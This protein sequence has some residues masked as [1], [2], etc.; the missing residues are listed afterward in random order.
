MKKT[1]LTIKQ[2]VNRTAKS[3]YPHEFIHNNET[4]TAPHEIANKFNSY[5][6]SIGNRLSNDVPNRGSFK[7]Y[8]SSP[9][10]V[11]FRFE[12][13]SENTVLLIIKQ[14]KYSSSTGN[15]GIS[16]ILLKHAKD[17]LVKPITLIVNQCLKS[18]IF[19]DQL[20]SQSYSFVQ[21]QKQLTF[22]KLPTDIFTSIDL[23]D[24]QKSNVFT[25]G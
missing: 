10:D 4:M 5:F 9:K 24:S 19:L 18:G 22:H 1:W 6:A 13:S 8:L 2:I 12:T 14:L 20:N 17:A 23:K 15:D 25:M 3:S 7:S 16:N 21:M 11:T